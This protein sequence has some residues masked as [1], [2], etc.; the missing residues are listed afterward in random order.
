MCVCA[1]LRP[2]HFLFGFFLFRFIYH[3]SQSAMSVCVAPTKI[4]PYAIL[5]TQFFFTLF[6]HQMHHFYMTKPFLS[7]INFTHVV[8]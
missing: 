2:F 7:E 6:N 4:V 3:R 5:S 8:C 1:S